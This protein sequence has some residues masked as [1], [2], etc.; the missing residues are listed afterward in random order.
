MN[1]KKFLQLRR[2]AMIAI[3]L[4]VASAALLAQSAGTAAFRHDYRSVR[5]RRAT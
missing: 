3:F 2:V 5:R 1:P 4:V